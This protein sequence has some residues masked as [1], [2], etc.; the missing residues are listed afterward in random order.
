MLLLKS[1]NAVDII[2]I[3]GT[4]EC[5]EADSYIRTA[6][7]WLLN[8]ASDTIAQ[9]EIIPRPRLDKLS[10]QNRLF[11][12][13]IN[14]F[15]GRIDEAVEAAG[16]EKAASA[17]EV[18]EAADV[19]STR[20]LGQAD[21][22]GDFVALLHAAHDDLELV[23]HGRVPMED[24]R[25]ASGTHGVTYALVSRILIRNSLLIQIRHEGLCR[26]VL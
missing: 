3:D 15:R 20:G 23:G 1:V 2:G 16:L 22:D 12:V 19:L 14:V 7:S 13:E 26:V 6:S 5:P 21:A 10:I 24:E 8:G 25:F 9:I 17:F 18:H 4:S 11:F